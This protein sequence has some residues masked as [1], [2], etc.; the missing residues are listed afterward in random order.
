[1][2]N[3][4]I[5]LMICSIT[6]YHSL[7]DPIKRNVVNNRPIIAVLAQKM[8]NVSYSGQSYIAASYVKYLESAGARVIPIP[9][10]LTEQEVRKLFQNV[11]GV[12]FPGGDTD[13]NN[14][15]YFRNAKIALELSI[16]EKMDKNNLFPIW[17]TCLGFQALFVYIAKT[18]SIVLGN[19]TLD[20][21][22]RNLQF[23]DKAADSRMFINLPQQLKKALSST[24]ITYNHHENGVT[25]TK[26]LKNES[27]KNFFK[28]LSTNIDTKGET[29]ISTTEAY[30]FPIYGTQWHPEK[31]NFEFKLDIHAA[32]NE[33]A[34]QA[35][36]YTASFFVNEARKNANRFPSAQV[37]DEYLIYKYQTITKE[38]V[39]EQIYVF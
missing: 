31:N 32:H 11:N 39:W 2:M 38:K 30:D 1:M 12:L 24:N 15:I 3:I 9:T 16:K 14:S 29:Y 28:V 10:N 23:T 17:G 22:C 4:F 18:P 33:M 7:C 36:L 34:V 25:M 21:V 19:V 26:Y 8:D 27:I 35:S 20:N 5:A 37:E 6:V 13:W